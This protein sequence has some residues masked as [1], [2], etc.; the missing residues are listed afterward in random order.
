MVSATAVRIRS[1]CAGRRTCTIA[2]AR[3]SAATSGHMVS[4]L[5]L[6]SL[7][8]QVEED[9]LEVWFLPPHLVHG[10]A[11]GDESAVNAGSH[12]PFHAKP[13]A[14]PIRPDRAR[15]EQP[16]GLV[17]RPCQRVSHHP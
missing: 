16:A 12:R 9:L 1:Q 17:L 2:S 11:F 10:D 13:Q 7:A 4:L 3:T 8:R 6:G 5:S 15:A 14:V